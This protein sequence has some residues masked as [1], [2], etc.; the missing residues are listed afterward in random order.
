VLLESPGASQQRATRITALL[1]GG[2]WIEAAG[3]RLWILLDQPEQG[4]AESLSRRLA[5]AVPGIRG[6][7]TMT[8]ST[9]IQA[10]DYMDRVIQI[11]QSNDELYI[12]DH[13]S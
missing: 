8:L 3:E 6:A 7:G 12:E 1:R 11:L 9:D 5:E 10:R 2:D 4:A 13:R